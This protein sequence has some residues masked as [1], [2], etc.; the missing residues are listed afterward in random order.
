MRNLYVDLGANW[1]NTLN[2]GAEYFPGRGAWLTVAFEASPL[3]Q[4]F[5]E[6]YV[7]FLNGERRTAPT[8][9]LPRS[10]S[11]VHLQRYAAALN[12][13]T[14]FNDAMRECVWEKLAVP[15]AQLRADP[16]LNSTALVARRLKLAS[17]LGSAP[18]ARGCRPHAVAVPA[19]VGATSGWARLWGTPQ[20]L[21][22]GGVK[23]TAPA[24]AGRGH[25]HIVPQVDVASWMVALARRVRQQ[26]GVVFVK[27]DVEGAEHAIV[28]RMEAVG[29]HRMLDAL[30]VECHD[31][32]CAAT[33]RRVHAWG[34]PVLTEATYGGMDRDAAA[35]TTLPRRCLLDDSQTLRARHPPSTSWYSLKGPGNADGTQTRCALLSTSGAL[36]LHQR[37]PDVDAHDVVIRTGQAPVRGFEQH[38]GRRTDYRIMAGSVFEPHRGVN[39]SKVRREF[40]GET[41]VYT[42]LRTSECGKLKRWHR[43]HRIAQP[44][45]CLGVGQPD[46]A[47]ATRWHRH[48]SSGFESVFIALN[49][50]NCTRITLF[51]FDTTEN[52]NAPYHY[53]ADGSYHDRVSGRQWY[54]SRGKTRYGHDF[55]AEQRALALASDHAVLTRPRLA[56]LCNRETQL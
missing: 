28:R 55:R 46:C 9:C 5:L 39:I 15:L 29:A 40:L 8:T 1:A 17:H 47:F 50:L 6:Q 2:L 31:P 11:T 41:I 35:E 7:G 36:L 52:L 44:Y 3:I 25:F 16:T 13:T 45:L 23:P 14:E 49:T 33:M 30:A 24:G 32:G 21:L 54:D 4:P 37:G 18:C 53:W 56:A 27:L 38:V 20:Q 42:K 10:G 19:A 26:H 43:Q 12:C 51:G 48:F 22:R 34:V